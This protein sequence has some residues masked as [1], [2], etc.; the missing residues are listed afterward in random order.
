M[1]LF[2]ERSRISEP[3]CTCRYHRRAPTR[4]N[5]T[6]TRAAATPIRVCSSGGTSRGTTWRCCDAMSRQTEQP[7]LP[8]DGGE[9]ARGDQRPRE[10]PGE[11]PSECMLPDRRPACHDADRERRDVAQ[12][13]AEERDRHDGKPAL[14]PE[15]PRD[16][17]DAR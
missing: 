7:L 15:V 17:M 4:A 8:R 6:K 3:R 13:A 11:P 12:E 9:D 16:E 5:A 1:R 2:S 14:E 10:G